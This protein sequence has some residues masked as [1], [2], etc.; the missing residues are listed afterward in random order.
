MP[1]SIEALAGRYPVAPMCPTAVDITQR[2][3]GL[4]TAINL[5]AEMANR[6]LTN[7]SVPSTTRPR[8]FI[9]IVARLR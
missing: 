7:R 3:M 2:F 6:R 1:R 5:E 8:E 4:A 9:A